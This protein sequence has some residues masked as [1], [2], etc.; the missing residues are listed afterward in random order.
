[1]ETKYPTSVV[2]L[3]CLADGT[4]S[5]YFSSGGGILGSGQHHTVALATQ[6]LVREA[7]QHLGEMMPA[8]AF[9]LPTAGCIQFTVLTYTEKWVACVPEPELEN[10]RHPLTSLFDSAQQVITQI[11]LIN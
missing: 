3:V 11:R 6:A 9:P 5:L 8:S 1:M 10:G 2:T 7:E 4:T